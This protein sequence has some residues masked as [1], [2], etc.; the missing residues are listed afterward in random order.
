MNAA[1]KIKPK[2]RGCKIP[3]EPKEF[4]SHFYCSTCEPPMRTCMHGAS[5]IIRC[6]ECFKK[7]GNPNMRLMAPVKKSNTGIRKR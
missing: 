3:F 4:Q 2:C 5:L 6:E 1:K 7:Y